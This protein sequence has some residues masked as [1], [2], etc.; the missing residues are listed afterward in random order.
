MADYKYINA[1]QTGVIKYSEPNVSLSMGSL[2]WEAFLEYKNQGGEVDSWRTKDEL[3]QDAL[4]SLWAYHDQLIAENTIQKFKSKS[5]DRHNGKLHAAI[6]RKA[7]GQ[8]SSQD[9]ALINA[10]DTLDHWF[11]ALERVAE[12]QGETWIEDPLRTDQEL[13]DFDPSVLEWPE[14]GV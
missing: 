2:G 12:D 9:D 4:S 1:S 13:I 8:N 10:N 5:H 3:Q 7:M 6:H 11:D 14:L